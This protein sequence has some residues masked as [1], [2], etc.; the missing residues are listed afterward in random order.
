[1]KML[2]VLLATIAMCVSFSASAALNDDE[3]ME[4]SGAITEGRLEVVKK[5]IEARPEL[6]KEK[7]FS[8]QPIQMA[9]TNNQL[10]VVQYLIKKGADLNYVHPLEKTSA[11]HLA[12]Y[13]G[14]KQVVKALVDGGADKNLKMKG[15]MSV[16]YVLRQEGKTDMADY[17][18]SLGINDEGCKT[19]CF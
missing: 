10:A 18:N 1:M 9:A 4:L 11:L 2:K 16:A 14:Y 3:Y 7:F 19:Q 12:A 6:V 8:W 5:Y 15:G 13:K 17:L